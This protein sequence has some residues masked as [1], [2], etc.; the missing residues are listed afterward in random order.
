MPRKLLALLATLALTLGLLL[1][2]PGAA[3]AASG[4]ENVAQFCQALVASGT[5][6]L[7]TQGACV[8]RYTTGN[9]TAAAAALCQE[10][11]FRAF[12]AAL[13]GREIANAGQCVAAVN[14]LGR[15]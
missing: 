3:G 2:T 7:L 15:E 9:S 4:E 10:A 8:A 6:D 1:A 5:T 13:A 12:I 14:A 11:E